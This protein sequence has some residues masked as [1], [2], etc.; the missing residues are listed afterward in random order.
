[1]RLD[2][3][4]PVRRAPRVKPDSMT[5]ASNEEALRKRI[6]WRAKR[7]TLELDRMVGWWLRQRMPN[8]D[9]ASIAA[10]DAMLDAQDPDLWDWLM[11][12]AKA[13]RADWQAFINDIRAAHRL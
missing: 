6:R 13:P 7:G 2:A 1:M 5:A 10:F 11:G 12:A 9:A 3:P 8:A 4:A